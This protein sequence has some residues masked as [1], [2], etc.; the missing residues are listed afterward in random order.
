MELVVLPDAAAVGRLAAD[1]V[2]QTLRR[3]P[4]PVLGLAT[5]STPGPLYAELVRRRRQEGL[6]FAAAVAFLLDEYVGL[7]SEHPQRYAAVIRRELTDCVDLGA[8]SGPDG[9]ALDLIAE[10]AAYEDA[11]AAAGGI[12]LQIAGIGTD[13]HVAFNEPGSSLDSLTRIKTLT[14]R[15]RGDNA[16]FFDTPEDVPRHVLTQGLGTIRRSRHLLLLATGEAKAGAVASAAEGPV[17][18][19]CP[20]SVLQ[21]HRHA[22]VLVDEAAATGLKLRGYYDEAWAGRP[23]WQPL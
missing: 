4:R 8:V 3:T 1:V 21:L 18:A 13:G 22:T 9:N 23:S 15:T 14:A 16:R 2:Q 5:G 19:S 7:P 12:D 10:C 11:I 17:S 6:S 20:A